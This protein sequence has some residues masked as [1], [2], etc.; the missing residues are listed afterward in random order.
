MAKQ[1]SLG[2]SYGKITSACM[3]VNV[4]NASEHQT[5]LDFATAMFLTFVIQFVNE[6]QADTDV[7]TCKFVVEKNAQR[8]VYHIGLL[9]SLAHVHT[10]HNTW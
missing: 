10:V 3:Y 9:R 8:R 6:Q 2:L 5:V 4:V 1:F 7:F